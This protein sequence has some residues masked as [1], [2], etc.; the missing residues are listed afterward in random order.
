MPSLSIILKLPSRKTPQKRGPLGQLFRPLDA[1]F[2]TIFLAWPGPLI[3]GPGLHPL[4]M[5]SEDYRRGRGKLEKGSPTDFSAD[6]SRTRAIPVSGHYLQASCWSFSI[7]MIAIMND[8]IKEK[9][10][11]KPC[12][13]ITLNFRGPQSENLAWSLFRARRVPC[14][15][16]IGELRL[17]ASHVVVH[18]LGIEKGRAQDAP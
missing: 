14:R 9:I 8:K 11:I 5:V 3:P 12:P 17:L 2:D 6:Q 15:I 13:G 7:T 4:R 1:S 18:R 16:I 10:L